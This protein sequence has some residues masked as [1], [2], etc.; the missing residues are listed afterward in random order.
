MGA[1]HQNGVAERAIRTVI[2]CAWTSL[3]HA[4]IR[5]PDNIDATL[6]PFALNH[7][8]YVWNEVPKEGCFSPSQ[9]LSKS[10][11]RDS[12]HVIKDLIVWGCPVYIL[13]Y[14]VANKKKL[15]K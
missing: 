3:I 5:N 14:Q 15:P 7:A 2:E 13:D 1:Q 10:F 12:L 4:A 6:G 11:A 8:C 9:N